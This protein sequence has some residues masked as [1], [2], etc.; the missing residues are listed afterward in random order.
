MRKR[1]FGRRFKKDINQRKALFRGLMRSLI[2]H[3]GI[4]TTEA[5]AKAIKG[6]FEKY[7]T[8]ARKGEV[9]RYHLLKH[10]PKESVDKLIEDIGPRFENRS[11]GYTRIIKLGN[12]TKDNAR[13]VL[14]ELI[15]K[16]TKSKNKITKKKIREEIKTQ[17]KSKKSIKESA[18][19]KINKKIDKTV[20]V[21]SE[22]KNSKK[23]K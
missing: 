6:Q 21:K 15:E 2:I 14:L 12:R 13:M 22:K 11:G 23:A 3:E 5:K 17:K 20:S 18:Q 16:S 10:L 9:S 8:K 7:I 1:V 19:K 4:K